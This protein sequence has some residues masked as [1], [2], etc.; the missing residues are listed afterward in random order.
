MLNLLLIIPF[1]NT[2][3]VFLSIQ[4]FPLFKLLIILNK[5]SS[6]HITI[7]L[8][9]FFILTEILFELIKRYNLSLSVT[10][11]LQFTSGLFGKSF[12]L[13]FKSQLTFSPALEYK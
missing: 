2:E 6:L 8:K 1:S 9:Y 5:S 7:F 10:I 4:K 12:P 11:N 3:H 13:M